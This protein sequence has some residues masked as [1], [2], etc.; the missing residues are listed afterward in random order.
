MTDLATIRPVHIGLRTPR[1][2][3]DR[4]LTGRARYIADMAPVGVVEVAFVRSQF[5]HARIRVDLSEARVAEGVVRAVSGEDLTDVRTMPE[6]VSWAQPVG[7]SVLATERVRYVG[8]PI[9]AV[10]ATDRYAAEDAAELVRVYY[11]PLPSVVSIEEAVAPN[12]L[13]LYDEWPDNQQVVV[14]AQDE[15]TDR[16]FAGAARVVRG[17]YVIQRHAAVPL[18]T[19]GCLAE[20]RDGRLTLWSST[21]I[22]HWV[23]AVIPSMLPVAER[24]VRVVAPDVGGS[25]GCKWH[26]Y[27]EELLV[28]WLA[29]Q[30]GRPVR[31][32]EDRAEHMVAACHARDAVYELEAAADERGVIQAVRGRCLQDVGSAEIYP[33]GFGPSF[34]GVGGL[35]GPYRIPHVKV[36]VVA[37]ATN[38]TP[39]GAYRGY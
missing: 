31:W 19:R 37:V 20:Y 32:I 14:P 2:E 30:L 13:R 29:M 9:A 22:P 38:K 4:L 28:S 21:Q 39:S 11:D 34:T 8:A 24:D 23:R 33:V 5:A 26:V 25:F 10:V 3:D 1:L 18:E 17:R 12:A 7:R 27:P 16:A 36:D 15:G 6:F 35:T